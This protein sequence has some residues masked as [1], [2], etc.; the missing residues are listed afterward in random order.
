VRPAALRRVAGRIK[1]AA[2][3][4]TPVT[5]LR[6]P[7]LGLALVVLAFLGGAGAAAVLATPSSPFEAPPRAVRAVLPVTVR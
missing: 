5:S 1:V 2:D 7:V 4:R 3:R 6:E